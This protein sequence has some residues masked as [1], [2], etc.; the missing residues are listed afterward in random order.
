VIS[1]FCCEVDEICALQGY[2]AAYGRFGTTYRLHLQGSRNPRWLFRNGSN[3][4]PLY[5]A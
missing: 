5:T 1:G 2:Y 4:L 3:E